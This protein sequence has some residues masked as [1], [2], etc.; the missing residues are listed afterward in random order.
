MTKPK[1]TAHS[2]T[3]KPDAKHPDAEPGA[4]STTASP[5]GH[6]WRGEGVEAAPVHG[7]ETSE[8]AAAR[9]EGNAPLPLES[10]AREARHALD[11]STYDPARPK[12]DSP[13]D[14][15]ENLAEKE[16]AAREAHAEEPS[17]HA[18]HGKL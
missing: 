13:D 12:S 8:A 3:G 9:A 11:P 16:E 14:S 5:K 18:P 10:A 4:A 15:A 7:E 17:R 1:S 6:A 2:Q